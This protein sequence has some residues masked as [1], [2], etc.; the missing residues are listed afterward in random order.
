M[1]KKPRVRPEQ[2]G[3]PAQV[4]K[5]EPEP[6]E[7]EY[8]QY[9]PEGPAPEEPQGETPEGEAGHVPSSGV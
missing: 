5:S 3:M 7:S 9:P 4:P 6:K 8:P 2:V 1:S